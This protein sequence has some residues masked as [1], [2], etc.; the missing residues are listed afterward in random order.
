MTESEFFNAFEK[1]RWDLIY[2]DDAHDGQPVIK[3]GIVAV[4][5]LQGVHAI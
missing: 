5:Y 4:F 2:A 1:H 3:V